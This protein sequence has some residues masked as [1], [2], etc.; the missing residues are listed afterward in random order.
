MDFTTKLRALVLSQ[1][2]LANRDPGDLALVIDGLAE[3]LGAALVVRYRDDVAQLDQACT[4][5]EGII[6]GA[7]VDQLEKLRAM[8]ALDWDG[9][10]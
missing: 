9:E 5:L 1:L 10:A 6:H 8:G 7:A 2:A 3:M 4:A